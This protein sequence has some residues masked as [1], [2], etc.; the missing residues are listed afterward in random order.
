MR[1]RANINANLVAHVACQQI[2]RDGQDSDPDIADCARWKVARPR[3][4][5]CESAKQSSQALPVHQAMINQTACF[6]KCS[7][8]RPALIERA[9]AMIALNPTL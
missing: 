6:S 7:A 2:P 4:N 1:P 5:V 9:A 3:T 8:P